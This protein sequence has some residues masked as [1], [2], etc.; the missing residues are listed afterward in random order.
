MGAI[1][2]LSLPDVIRD[3][4]L[5]VDVW[6][7]WQTR[8]RSSGGYDS[9]LGVQ[10]HHTA[11]NTTPLRDMQY[12]WGGSP[13]RPV[14]AIYLARNAKVTVGAAGATNTS[15]RGGPL[16]SIPLDSANR[17]VI[18]V[19]AANSGTG[20]QWPAEQQEAYLIL[21]NAL[22]RAY[23]LQFSIPG[24]HAH[25]EWTTRKIDP[26]GNSRWATGGAKWN[27]HVFRSDA[28]AKTP[29]PP[30]VVVPPTPEPN[31]TPKGDLMIV[32][33]QPTDCAAE[34]IGMQDKNGNVLEIE[35]IT[36]VEGIRHRD[37][38]IAAG[39]EVKKGPHRNGRFKN[40]TLTGP[41]PFGDSY[42]WSAADFHRVRS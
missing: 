6:P 23:N 17:H 38:H 37:A 1:W 40:C 34:F 8:A 22:V 28:A 36:G 25:H 30:P 42:P 15:G 14:G 7:G 31:P 35:W 4:G 29:I 32:V 24:L 13:D 39:A 10:A 27:M 3:A 2:L 11:S 21:S 16:G 19:E 41:I 18:S 26:A 9:I 33:F 20:E 5:D 12:M